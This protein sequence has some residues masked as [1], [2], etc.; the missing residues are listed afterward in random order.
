[1]NQTFTFHIGN[2][3]LQIEARNRSKAMSKANDWLWDVKL[4]EVRAM[5]DF[6]SWHDDTTPNTYVWTK[7]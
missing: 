6:F 3:T 4:D 1:M 5:G 2:S 7:D